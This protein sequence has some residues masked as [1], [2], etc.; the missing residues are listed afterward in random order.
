M[1]TM[2]NIKIDKK[3]KDE[4]KKIADTMGIPLGTITNILLRQ[5]VRDKEI[6]ISLSYKPS[7]RL[8]ESIDEAD[9]EYKKGSM[10]EYKTSDELF[11]ALS[12]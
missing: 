3:M 4:A 11:K 5:F 9:A 1:K 12:V 6:N 7:K 2:L 8:I 10:K